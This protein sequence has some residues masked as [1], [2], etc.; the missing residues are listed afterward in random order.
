MKGGIELRGLASTIET[1]RPA[2]PGEKVLTL[3]EFSE[4]FEFHP[5]TV[6]ETLIQVHKIPTIRIDHKGTT[7]YYFEESKA[8]D[9]LKSYPRKGDPWRRM[10]FIQLARARH[11]KEKKENEKK[12]PRVSL[13][14][15]AQVVQEHPRQIMPCTFSVDAID[16][17]EFFLNFNAWMGSMR[18]TAVDLTLWGIAG[19]GFVSVYRLDEVICKQLHVRGTIVIDSTLTIHSAEDLKVQIERDANDPMTFYFKTRNRFKD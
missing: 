5:A 17:A 3:R 7:L 19:H 4:L 11:A 14:Y 15:Q 13:Q 9:F 18:T 2:I 1:L 12:R 8:R 10:H 6:K 16:T